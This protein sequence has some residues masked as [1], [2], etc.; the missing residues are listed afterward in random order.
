MA[1][2]CDTPPAYLD[3]TDPPGGPAKERPR[4]WNTQA[5]KCLFAEDDDTDGECINAYNIIGKY[6]P[7]ALALLQ[8][9]LDFTNFIRLISECTYPLDNIAFMLFLETVRWYSMQTTTQ[10]NYSEQSLDFWKVRYRLMG[11]RFLLFMGGMK[12]QGQ[13]VSGSAER[14][15]FDP[16]ESN[17]NFAVPSTSVVRQHNEENFPKVLK[18]GVK[19]NLFSTCRGISVNSTMKK[20]S[21]QID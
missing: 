19:S 15:H 2:C 17:I 5:K 7:T 12:N 20:T 18:A 8:D 14:G 11:D 21:Y 3:N 9:L 16:K 10:M 13:V 1:F 4:I 6:L